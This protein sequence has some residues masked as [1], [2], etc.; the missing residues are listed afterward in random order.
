MGE[1]MKLSL[2]AGIILFAAV[3]GLSG[4]EWALTMEM[5]GGSVLWMDTDSAGNIYA[6]GSF[7]GNIQ[8]QNKTIESKSEKNFQSDMFIA[9]FSPDG[10]IRWVSTG[11]GKGIDSG[12]CVAVGQ[13]NVFVAGQFFGSM[14]F[15]GGQQ[16]KEAG[17]TSVFIGCYGTDGSMKWVKPVSDGITTHISKIAV[18]NQGNLFAIGTFEGKIVDFGEKKLKSKDGGGIFIAKYSPDGKILWVSQ[19]NSGNSF[20]TKVKSKAIAVDTDGSLYIAGNVGGWGSFNGKVYK[21]SVTS[22][23]KNEKIP[24]I[25]AFIAKYDA[26][27]KFLWIKII[28]YAFEPRDMKIDSSGAFVITGIMDG[29]GW[30]EVNNQKI[31]VFGDKIITL[32]AKNQFIIPQDIFI[33]K[34]DSEAKLVWVENA[35]GYEEDYSESLV[36]DGNDNSV[37]GGRFFDSM[38]I[39]GNKLK[40]PGSDY[41]DGFAAMYNKSGKLQWVKQAG[42]KKA[43]YISCIAV[44]PDGAVYA[45]GC[46]EGNVLFGEITLVARKWDSIFIQRMK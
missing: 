28:G 38:V 46:F 43:D 5:D 42:G 8:Y 13:E 33:A 1:V 41:P 9:S 32:T 19:I 14:E 40:A 16:V 30:P 21:T 37:I 7:K 34:Y 27:G 36:L 2:I 24:N 17:D 44:S 39:G 23:S 4:L 12:N 3:S 25:E 29:L 10:S 20:L 15:D 35:G 45:G 22:Y 31:A 18:D 6:A 11:G 26:D